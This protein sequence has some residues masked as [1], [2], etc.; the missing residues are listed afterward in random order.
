MMKSVPKYWRKFGE[1]YGLVG[2]RCLSCGKVHY[3]KVL[4]CPK[5]MGQTEDFR[6]SGSGTV[7]SFTVVRSGP[8]GFERYVPYIIAI[9]E[10]DEGAKCVGQI[11]DCS[12]E[13][14]YIGTKLETCFRKVSEDGAG[15]IIHYGLKWKMKA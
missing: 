7:F 15:G 11:V 8:T 14:I 10:L 2:S 6:F 5:C 1:R 13:E 3:P 9:I 4:A 12:P